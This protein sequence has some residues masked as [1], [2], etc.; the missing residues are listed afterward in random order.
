MKAYTAQQQTN[1]TVLVEADLPQPV[2]KANEVLVEVKAAGV[3]PSE[4]RWYP[5]THNQDGSPR[6]DAVPGHEFSGVI[7]SVGKD[8]RFTVGD[9]V[10]GI[11]GWFEDGATAQLCTCAES[12]LIRKPASLSHITAAV[13]PISGQTAWQGLVNHAKMKAGDRVLVVGA[14]GSVGLMAVQVA[15]LH[16][17]AIFGS[18]SAN[19]ESTLKALG[20]QQVLD[21]KSQPFQDH[22][23]NIDIVFDTVG[24]DTLACAEKIL[25]PNARMVTIAADAEGSNDPLI[26]KA[27]FTMEP[28]SDQLQH[29]A[30]L[31]QQGKLHPF[32]KAVLPFA[33]AANVYAGKIDSLAL[34]KIALEIGCGSSRL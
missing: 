28:S 33:E 21:Y 29:I 34:G 22:L 8:T 17:C 14:S 6:S 32:I 3:T 7:T 30:Q 23:E 2:P 25:A 13:I 20:C 18:A 26:K 12:G 24:G 11:S 31:V 4:L 10:F 5:T 1:K 16:G 27:Y 15:A 9:E 19:S